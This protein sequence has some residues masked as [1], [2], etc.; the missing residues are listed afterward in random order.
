M[1]G[2]FMHVLANRPDNDRS[3]CCWDKCRRTRTWL[4]TWSNPVVRHW[5]GKSNRNKRRVASCWTATDCTTDS[6]IQVS[7]LWKGKS[8]RY[9]THEIGAQWKYLFSSSRKKNSE[10]IY[11]LTA[12][13][14]PKNFPRLFCIRES[15]KLTLEIEKSIKIATNTALVIV[16]LCLAFSLRITSGRYFY[17]DVWIW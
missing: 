8:R 14:V 4:L 1:N 15:T 13:K 16:A 2:R 6:A 9:T 17:T 11:C 10:E 7:S 12:P 3:W 5:Y